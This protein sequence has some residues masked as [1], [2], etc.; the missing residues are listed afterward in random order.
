MNLKDLGRLISPVLLDH[1][2]QGWFGFPGAL[3]PAGD[4]AA[5]LSSRT[6]KKSYFSLKEGVFKILLIIIWYRWASG[7]KALFFTLLIVMCYFLPGQLQYLESIVSFHLPT[8]LN[9]LFVSLSMEREPIVLDLHISCVPS[10]SCTS[11]WNGYLCIVSLISMV[12]PLVQN[13]IQQ[14]YECKWQNLWF[15]GKLCGAGYPIRFTGK[16]HYRVESKDDHKLH[17]RKRFILPFLPLAQNSRTSSF[18]QVGEFFP[19]TTYTSLETSHEAWYYWDTLP[20]L[21]PCRWDFSEWM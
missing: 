17:L 15:F 18:F 21:Q 20:N 6:Q 11:W 9:G 4:Q 3:G 2:L 19:A 5:E 10:R 7:E 1:L 8:I 14:Q 12:L 16:M 13:F